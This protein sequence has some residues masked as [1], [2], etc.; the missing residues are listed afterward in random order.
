MVEVERYCLDHDMTNQH[1][2]PEVSDQG[3]GVCKLIKRQQD[4]KM[5]SDRGKEWLVVRVAG[6]GLTCCPNRGV[7]R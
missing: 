5:R 4:E 6:N 7:K 2:S 3:L 1:Q